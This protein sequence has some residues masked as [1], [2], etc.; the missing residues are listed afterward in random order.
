[1]Q[2]QGSGG[3]GPA[4]IEL[5]S[6]RRSQHPS[7][8]SVPAPGDHGMPSHGGPQWRMCR[9][10]A[11]APGE[12]G[13]MPV[14]A[15]RPRRIFTAFHPEEV[16]RIV[17]K[18][19]LSV[20]RTTTSAVYPTPRPLVATMDHARSV[21]LQV[22]GK[23]L[24]SSGPDTPNRPI[25]RSPALTLH[26]SVKYRSPVH[27]RSFAGVSYPRTDVRGVADHPV[28]HRRTGRHGSTSDHAQEV[29]PS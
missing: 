27:R 19:E 13:E 7:W 17:L 29:F 22:D 4:G 25:R 5:P 10:S 20:R 9:H 3:S 16:F 11:P 15:A 26:C 12:R 14:T 8:R 18:A 1:M 24:P 21:H 23:N 6:A 2:S 28:V